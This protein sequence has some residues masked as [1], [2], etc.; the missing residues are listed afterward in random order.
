MSKLFSISSEIVCS[1][2][3]FYKMMLNKINGKM[4]NVIINMYDS[5]KSCISY[6]N[7]ISEYFD[8]ANGVRQGEN[9]F[10]FLF[11]LFLNDI[12]TFLE[13]KNITGLQTIS[14]EIEN[15]L[16]IYLKLFILLYADDTALLAETAND[17]QTHTIIHINN[18]IIH[19]A[20]DFI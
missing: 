18:N 20:I 4:Y 6:N 3:I 15:N 12:D 16:D 2:V 9:L 5:I 14:D 10:S 17:L 7:C 19:F 11:S 13:N 8:C 1:P